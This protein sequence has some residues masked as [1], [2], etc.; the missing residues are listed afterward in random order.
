MI[1]NN[2]ITNITKIPTYLYTE[3]ICIN[4][5]GD[6]KEYVN[7]Y[8]LKEYVAGPDTEV[9]NKNTG[10]TCGKNKK[11]YFSFYD[12]DLVFHPD[13]IYD[14]DCYGFRKCKL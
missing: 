1:E 12:K 5:D 11:I 7:R 8:V 2:L 3:K 14:E 13:G 4:E 6:I 9:Y 10:E